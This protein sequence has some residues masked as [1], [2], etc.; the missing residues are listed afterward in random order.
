LDILSKGNNPAEVAKYM[1]DCFNG[2]KTVQFKDDENG[3]QTSFTSGMISSDDERVA[4]F[5]NDFNCVG[6]VEEW[7][8]NLDIHVKLTL[9]G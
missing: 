3:N 1:M 5:F 8:Y 6:E 2:L 4:W 7:L 9:Q